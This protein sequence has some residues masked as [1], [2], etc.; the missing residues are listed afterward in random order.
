MNEKSI[1]ETD[2]SEPV[3]QE[4]VFR[5]GKKEQ[6]EAIISLILFGIIG[7]GFI[8]GM[9]LNAPAETRISATLFFSM[10]WGL[11]MSIFFWSFLIAK[12]VSV[13]FHNGNLILQGVFSKKY[14]LLSNIDVIRWSLY[15]HGQIKVETATEVGTI[16]LFYFNKEERLWMIQYFRDH[17]LESRQEN[18]PLFCHQIAL[19]LRNRHTIKPRTPRPDDFLHTRKRWDKLIIIFAT[20]TALISILPAWYFQQIKYLLLPIL[21]LCGWFVRYKIPEEG[22]PVSA[23]E[24]KNFNEASYFF[25]IWSVACLIIYLP[26]RFEL[27]P[28]P[29]GISVGWTITFIWNFGLYWRIFLMNRR[30]HQKDL[31]DAKLSVQEWEAG[32]RSSD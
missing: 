12:Y 1:D 4:R 25:G 29:T 30:D 22:I 7:L 19:P 26:F 15:S 5:Q 2:L 17:F 3:K 18:W 16:N 28:A 14:I 10:L 8:Y 11:L 6:N 27:L 20:V 13:A 9:C 24:N 32:N 23:S 21:P 31:E